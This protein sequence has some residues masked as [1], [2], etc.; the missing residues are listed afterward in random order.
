MSLTPVQL[1]FYAFDY[2]DG[3][4]EAIV[5]RH[6]QTMMDFP[7]FRRFPSAI[8]C[9]NQK[10]PNVVGVLTDAALQSLRLSDVDTAST[11]PP[12]VDAGLAEIDVWADNPRPPPVTH[13]GALPK[14]YL[15]KHER[16][17][18]AVDS[19]FLYRGWRRLNIKISLIA[20]SDASR[21]TDCGMLQRS[22][23]TLAI[24][25]HHERFRFGSFS[26]RART[27]IPV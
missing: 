9:S 20:K 6:S 16:P 11:Y 21:R 27:S 17:L 1:R 22:A 18:D 12:F 23:E 3:N 2:G 15:E 7:K 14:C 10:L 26:G 8:R 24:R 5:A 19:N 13:S 4:A 25:H